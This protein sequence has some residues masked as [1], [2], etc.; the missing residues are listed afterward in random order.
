MVTPRFMFT[1]DRKWIGL[2]H[3]VCR[4]DSRQLLIASGFHVP[5]VAGHFLTPTSSKDRFQIEFYCKFAVV[6]SRTICQPKCRLRFTRDSARFRT[7]RFIDLFPHCNFFSHHAQLG[8][9]PMTMLVWR[10]ELQTN[11]LSNSETEQGLSIKADRVI[12][13]V[14]RIDDSGLARIQMALIV[15]S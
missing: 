1:I 4:H 8:L 10:H 12:Q 15:A 2:S 13:S 3:F 7:Q 6:R 5:R 14:V 11:V 9:F